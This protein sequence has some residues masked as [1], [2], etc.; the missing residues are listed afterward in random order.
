MLVIEILRGTPPWVFA[1]LG[2]LAWRG[3]V[4]LKGGTSTPRRSAI[5]PMVFIVWGLSG[6]FQHDGNLHDLLLPWLAGCCVGMLAGRLIEPMPGIDRAA[7]LLH[8]G[9]SA[10]PLVR[11][12]L[13]FCMHYFLHVAAALDAGFAPRMVA[14]DLLVSGVS[15]GYFLGWAIRLWRAWRAAPPAVPRVAGS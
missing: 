10:I 9:P 4:R 6:L 12:V 14:W 5:V 2:Y 7:G 3:A 11:N 8:F 1:L 15:A 13:L